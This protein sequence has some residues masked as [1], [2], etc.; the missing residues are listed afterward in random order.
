MSPGGSVLVSP[1]TGRPVACQTSLIV[2]GPR[3][4]IQP[5]I[6]IWNVWKTSIRKTITEGFYQ[7]GEARDKLIHGA[8]LR[9]NS[10]FGVLK[11]P[12]DTESAGVCPLLLSH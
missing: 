7:R 5:A 8:G 11:Q 2:W 1:D 12:Q 10:V 3:Q 6:R 4:T 9:A